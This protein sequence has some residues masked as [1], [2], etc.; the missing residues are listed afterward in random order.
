MTFDTQE[1]SAEGGQPIELFKFDLGGTLYT[2]TNQESTQT[3]DAI[4]Y[5]P[6]AISRGKIQNSFE[7]KKTQLTITVPVD[8]EFAQL[9][10]SIIP[11]ETAILEVRQVHRTD[12]ADQT[13]LIFK[14]RVGT[15][16][17]SNDGKSAKITCRPIMA[18]V[19]RPIPR[20]TY[21]GL[22]NHMHY[23]DR[24]TVVQGSFEETGSV[25]TV[26]GRNITT[27]GLTNVSSSDYW[28]A[29]FVQFGVEYRLIVAQTDN[30]FRLNL[31]F[32][33][34]IVGETLTFLPGCKHRRSDCATKFSNIENYGGYPFVPTKNPFET[35]LD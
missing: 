25:T 29:G 26:N 12:G 10:I 15:V 30:V 17:F 11:G 24:C 20:H 8:N 7:Q 31:P 16:G 6:E 33:A 27:S 28:E 18:A 5:T 22:C 9:F 2:Y 4:V 23:D 32:S 34:D 13:V 14:G 35:G 3:F 1:R 21:Q 19:E